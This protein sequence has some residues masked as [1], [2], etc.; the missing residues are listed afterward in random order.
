[1]A[2][3]TASTYAGMRESASL[4]AAIAV[5]S[6]SSRGD[7]STRSHRPNTMEQ[8]MDPPQRQPRA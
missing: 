3:L 7:P 2:Q 5:S 6:Y 4:E 1:M 8:T